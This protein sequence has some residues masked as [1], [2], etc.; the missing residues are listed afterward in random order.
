MQKLQNEYSSIL[1]SPKDQNAFC[2][3][4]VEMVGLEEPKDDLQASVRYYDDLK[5]D[6]SIKL[7]MLLD[8]KLEEVIQSSKHLYVYFI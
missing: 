3:M 2:K 8:E 1:A 6:N 5:A 7:K 4:F